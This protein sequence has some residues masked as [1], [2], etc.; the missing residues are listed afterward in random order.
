MFDGLHANDFAP[1]RVRHVMT[2]ARAVGHRIGQ[3]PGRLPTG[4]ALTQDV[5]IGMGRENH[6]T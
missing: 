4:Q 6:Q 2:E 1:S 3:Q 5:D